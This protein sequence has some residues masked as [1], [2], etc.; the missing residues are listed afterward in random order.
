M[1]ITELGKLGEE[2]GMEKDLC[3]D[4]PAK[5][6]MTVDIQPETPRRQGVYRET[7]RVEIHNWGSAV[8]KWNLKP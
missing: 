2:A 3:S 5:L 1:L 8:E 7:F 4:G 6:E